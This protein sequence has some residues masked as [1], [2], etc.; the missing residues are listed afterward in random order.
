MIAASR[1]RLEVVVWS[2][3]VAAALATVVGSGIVLAQSARTVHSGV[4]AGRP[5]S[6]ST[7]KLP[8][9]TVPRPVP[10]PPGRP[11]VHVPRRLSR[12]FAPPG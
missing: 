2:T 7:V 1:D 5:D 6:I 12:A 11:A 8:A 4:D 9:P 3:V 10:L